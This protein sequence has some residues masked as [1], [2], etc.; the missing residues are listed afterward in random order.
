MNINL[1]TAF[2]PGKPVPCQQYP[3]LFDP[4]A[5]GERGH[6]TRR[7]SPREWRAID[8]CDDCHA[9]NDCRIWA[10]YHQKNDDG[11][12][13][14]D[15]HIYGGLTGTQRRIIRGETPIRRRRIYSVDTHNIT[16]PLGGCQNG[17]PPTSK[18]LRPNGD[19]RCRQCDAAA[20]RRKRIRDTQHRRAVA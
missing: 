15:N 10:L 5:R 12:P 1:G 4:P 16:A 6:D 2:N 14:E 19:R 9:F 18:Y 20:A 13:Y 3:W 17:H 11:Q 7:P 8:M